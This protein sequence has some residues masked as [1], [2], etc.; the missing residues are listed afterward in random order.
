M[1]AHAAGRAGGKCGTASN[2]DKSRSHP[3]TRPCVPAEKEG[4][5][6]RKWCLTF[7]GNPCYTSKFALSDGQ[8]TVG[9]GLMPSNFSTQHCTI[10]V[11]GPHV[12]ICPLANKNPKVRNDVLINNEII[13]GQ[14][15]V[16][17]GD[18]VT[19]GCREKPGSG[20]VPL[21]LQTDQRYMVYCKEADKEP[22]QD[23]LFNDMKGQ[24]TSLPCD[25]QVV[26]A[27]LLLEKDVYANILDASAFVHNI[28][29]ERPKN[30]QLKE[31]GDS[32][33]TLSVETQADLKFLIDRICSVSWTQRFVYSTGF[34]G[35]TVKLVAEPGDKT[36]EF[37]STTRMFPSMQ[38]LRAFVLTRL[39]I[40]HAIDR[41][42]E[43]SAK[44]Q[45]LC[46]ARR[47]FDGQ[48]P[49]DETPP[50]YNERNL[51]MFVVQGKEGN[52]W[53]TQIM[54]KDEEDDENEDEEDDEDEEI[55]SDWRSN[56]YTERDVEEQLHDVLQ[57]TAHLNCTRLP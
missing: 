25:M 14:T 57:F 13:E 47:F 18:I 30:E 6:D 1:S 8:Q 40:V 49:P 32:F 24:L 39:A 7:V 51:T 9:R 11:N 22:N 12:L 55:N 20:R 56:L 28:L 31:D 35:V 26:L 54:R 4:A 27:F 15:Q 53:H 2:S 3:Y 37:T 33:G 23:K 43:A 16:Q 34:I 5:D 44:E 42:N 29:I 41:F 38:A 21:Y 17:S 45:W 36:L 10:E 50:G 48:P 19:F 52:S 46:V